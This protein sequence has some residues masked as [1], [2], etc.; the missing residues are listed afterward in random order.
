MAVF[1]HGG[2]LDRAITQYGGNRK[3]WIDLSTGINPYS[4][5]VSNLVSSLSSDFLR[6]L[7]DQQLIETT[8]Q[9]A[10]NAYQANFSGLPLAGAQQ[11]IQLFPSIIEVGSKKACILHPSYNEYEAQLQKAGWQITHCHHLDEM[12]GADCAIIANP[13]NPDGRQFLPT[14]LLELAGIV[15]TLIIDESFCDLY[16]HLSVLP[17]TTEQHQNI[18]IFRSFGKFYGL[19]GLRLGFVFSHSKT[20]KQFESAAGKWAVSAPALAIGAGALQ[21]EN[22]RQ[23]TMAKLTHDA[24][25]LDRIAHQNGLHLIGGTDLFRLYQW[26]NAKNMQDK[27]AGHKI[28]SRIFSYS[29]NW[30]RLGIPTDDSWERVQRALQS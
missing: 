7:P 9:S 11:A 8:A 28:W 10:R 30:I 24:K 27:L 20:L 4:Y 17:L 23:Q 13:N 5:P 6:D 2:D 3:D 29:E 12:T 1:E 22:W 16:P 15:G 19:A 25:R 26:D 14:E 18:I 21:D